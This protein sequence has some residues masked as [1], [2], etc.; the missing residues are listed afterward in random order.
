MLAGRAA[1]R[2]GAGLVTMAIPSLLH[3]VLAG[4]FPEATWLLLP[5]ETGVIST[6]ATDVLLNHLDHAKALLLGPGFGAEETTRNFIENLIKGKSSGKKNGSRIGF[7]HDEKK[8]GD[9]KVNSLP[10]M[11]VDADG[12]RLIKK[13]QD[14]DKLLPPMTVLTPHPGEMAELTGKS[15]AEI[16][17]DRQDI[18]RAYS[19]LW[20]HVVVLKGALTVIAK[21][22]GRITVIPVA[23]SALAKAGTGDVLSGLIV[24]LLAQ[25][26]EPYSAA[27]AGAWIHAQAGLFALDRVGNPASVMASDVIDSISDVLIGLI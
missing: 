16:Q 2:V 1:Y 6:E 12:L 22:D 8:T 24:G 4:Q 25:G 17:S 15:I 14:W 13:I 18:A 19:K 26:V 5:H 23:S 10:P 27:I 21:P 3:P 7:V 11:V 9:P 20:G